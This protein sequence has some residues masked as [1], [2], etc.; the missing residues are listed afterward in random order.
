MRPVD[1]PHAIAI[2][3]A[4]RERNDGETVSRNFW[5]RV[6]QDEMISALAKYNAETKVTILRAI[7]D[8]WRAM[9]LEEAGAAE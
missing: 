2:L 5:L 8:E 1:T 3:Q 9:K 7:I 6:D 4:S